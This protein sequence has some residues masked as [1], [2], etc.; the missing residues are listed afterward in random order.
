MVKKK[1][2]PP[3]KPS[4]P[5]SKHAELR[6]LEED[7]RELY[8]IKKRFISDPK[9]GVSVLSELI[10]KGPDPSDASL[11]AS[12]NATILTAWLDHGDAFKGRK[13]GARQSETIYI[14][15][16]MDA[17][18]HD[19]SGS[20]WYKLRKFVENPD[21]ANNPTPGACP[22]VRSFD[23]RGRMILLKRGN[24]YKEGAFKTTLTSI[25][26]RRKSG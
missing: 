25:R 11:S 16:L 1:A 7:A 6:R 22:F 19:D 21:D 24:P 13:F 5:L 12:T 20:L 17:F 9:A 18:P 10:D 2:V 26:K 14:E 23:K 4:S 3:Q 15:E 8:Y